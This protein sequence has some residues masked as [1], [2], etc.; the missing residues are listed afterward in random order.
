MDE[1][2]SDFRLPEPVFVTRPHYAR[3]GFLDFHERVICLLIRNRKEFLVLGAGI[4]GLAAARTIQARGGRITVLEAAPVAGGLTRTIVVDEFRFDYT[5]HF[6][7]L[8]RYHHAIRRAVCRLAR[9]RMDDGAAAGRRGRSGGK[10]VPAPIQYSI[11]KLPKAE[12]DAC[13]QAYETRPQ[14]DDDAASSSFRDFTIQGFGSH[15]AEK[16]LI[17]QKREDHGRADLRICHPPP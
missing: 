2:T 17:P 3:A 6:L 9:Q 4:S 15:L 11:G 8:S 5:G 7:H 1:L 14:P 13:I 10:L 12:R 16:Y